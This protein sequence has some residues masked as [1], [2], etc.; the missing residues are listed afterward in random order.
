MLSEL[1]N[2]YSHDDVLRIYYITIPRV[3]E[4]GIKEHELK[5]VYEN[6]FLSEWSPDVHL[7]K[8]TVCKFLNDLGKSCFRITAFMR[9]RT[10]A[11][12]MDHHLLVDGTL[13]PS[14][15]RINSFPGFSRKPDQRIRRS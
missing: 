3:C 1:Q 10:E 15:L 4:H 5:E 11:M 8:N 7:S 14:E 9:A 2:F 13:K 12:D 6:N